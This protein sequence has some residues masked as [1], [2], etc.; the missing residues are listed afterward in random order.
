MPCYV[1]LSVGVVQKPQTGVGETERKCSKPPCSYKAAFFVIERKKSMDKLYECAKAF[2][3]LLNNQYRIII[4][5]KGQSVELCIGFS[6]IDFHHLMGLG[7]L[8]DLRV[9]REDRV[10]VFDDIINTV[11]TFESI[12]N[13]Q[14]IN[15]IL[16]RFEPL[17]N[18][19]SLLD[20]NKLIFRYNEKANVFSLI[21]ADYLLSTPFK[22]NQIYIFIEENKDTERFYCKSFFPK[23]NKDYTLGQTAFTLL[24]KE[25]INLLS[26]EQ[27]IQYNRLSSLPLKTAQVLTIEDRIELAQSKS[28]QIN[29]SKSNQ[30]LQ[31]KYS[32]GSER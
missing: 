11:T 4:G 20:S 32:K 13:S 25:K 16:D 6:K 24:Y 15:H 2:E 5:R 30:Q 12:S 28:K 3:K 7:K 17:F 27:H 9:A 22:E 31:N 18:I 1:E 8:K 23:T 29:K 21:Q 10:T 14:Y 19:E 26:G